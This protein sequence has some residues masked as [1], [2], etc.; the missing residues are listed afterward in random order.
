MGEIDV[1]EGL[2]VYNLRKPIN[3]VDFESAQD[4]RWDM[5]KQLVLEHVLPLVECHIS[6][7]FIEVRIV[8]GTMHQYSKTEKLIRTKLLESI[9]EK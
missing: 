6:E 7:G 2:K 1:Y 5:A 3:V 4:Q 9:E 8:A